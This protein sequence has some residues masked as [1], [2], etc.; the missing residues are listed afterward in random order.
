MVPVR[1]LY[2][3]YFGLRE[4]LVQTQ[5]LPYLRE[6]TAR[7]VEM[8]LLTFEPE[9]FDQSEWRE[10]LRGDGINWYTL[11]YHK[12][13]TLP[14]TLYDIVRGAFRAASIARRGKIGILHGRSH[15]GAA[16]GALAKR[17][18]GARLIFDFR[19]LLA[20]EYVDHGNWRAG[21]VLFRLTKGAERWLL[22][23]A[24]GV[25]FL[26]QAIADKNVCAPV[27]VIPCCVDIERYAGAGRWELGVADR[28]VYVYSGALGGYYLF[29]EMARLV[30]ADP[31][32]FA[33]IL[34]KSDPQPMTDALR[35]AGFS[36]ADFRVLSVAPEDVP[37]YLRASD[38]G[39]SLIRQSPARR[40]ASPTK[41]AEYLAAGLPVIHSAAVGDLDAQI[42]QHRVGVL[43]RSLDDAAYAE[44]IRAVTELR[45]DP[46]L[47]ARCRALAHAEY[48]LH[49]VGGE[50]YRR[51]YDA[52]L[53]A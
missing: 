27:E 44:A 11:R 8:S 33:L 12:R 43:V 41:F 53:R 1:S 29:E 37:K 7:G 10:R 24:D 6:L 49:D 31:R 19:G 16:I 18:C 32:A 35:R 50:R 5:V 15:V 23:D 26:T 2:I 40:A 48:D 28:V 46:E 9:P 45:R 34:T 14:A 36:A 47:E 13:P 38:V 3:C 17:M 4:P 21:G 42:E 20:E 25:V 51:L 22:R 52:V 30:R 39:I